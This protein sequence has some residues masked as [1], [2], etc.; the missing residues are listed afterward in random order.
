[1]TAR[2]LALAA[3]AALTASPALADPIDDL[4]R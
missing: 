3:V 4:V 1:M 2:L